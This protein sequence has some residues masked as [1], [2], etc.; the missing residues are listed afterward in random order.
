MRGIAKEVKRALL[1]KGLT[2]STAES[3]TGGLVSKMITDVPG[4]S[5][6][7]CGGVIA[8]SSSAKTDVLGIDSKLIRSMGAVSRETA[9]ELAKKVK[10]LFNTDIGI[11]VTGIAGPGAV[12]QKKVGTVY[13]AIVY[14][15][16][17]CYSW[18][19]SGSRVR[20]RKVAAESILEELVKITRR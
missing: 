14:D 16:V 9:I 10:S 8:Y 1:S 6:Y 2:V 4:S 13:G 20:I 3:V 18:T 7:F 17:Y 12:E 11:G 5:N 19:F 15:K